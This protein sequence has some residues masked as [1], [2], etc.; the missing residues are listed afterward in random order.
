VS[1]ACMFTKPA[2]PHKGNAAAHSRIAALGF[3]GC[4]H[5]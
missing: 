2:T 1:H 3:Q 5:P 4:N